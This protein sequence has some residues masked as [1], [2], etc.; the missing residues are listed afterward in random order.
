MSV[1]ST[2]YKTMSKY[3]QIIDTNK[4]HVDKPDKTWQSSRAF[5]DPA[6][7]G[8]IQVKSRPGKLH[9]SLN[10]EY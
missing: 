4:K 1:I 3:S 2:G 10:I 6:R 8:G 7:V 9:R 5:R